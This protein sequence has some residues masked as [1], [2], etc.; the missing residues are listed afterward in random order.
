MKKSNLY[1]R[2]GDT[3]TTSLVGGQRVRKD[4]I[5]IE[6]YGTIDELNSHIGLL[7][8]MMTEDNCQKAILTFIQNKLFNIGAYLATENPPEKQAVCYGL[9]KTA[10]EK[11]EKEIDSLDATVPPLH[12]FLLS[13]GNPAASQAHVCRTVCRRAERNII[14]LSETAYIDPDLMRFINRLSDYLFVLARFNNFIAKA[15]EI[16]WDKDC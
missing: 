16:F 14:S 6:S 10:I 13:G 11:L 12:A 15:S 9:G 8:S 3:G 5:R 1:T 4:D 7:S 2:T